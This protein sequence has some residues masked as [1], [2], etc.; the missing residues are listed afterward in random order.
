MRHL[1]PG[2]SDTH[3]LQPGI[4]IPRSAAVRGVTGDILEDTSLLAYRTGF[5]R[6]RGLKGISALAAFP[7]WL[8][9][10]IAC[11]FLY[12]HIS[13]RGESVVEWQPE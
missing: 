6:Y 5:W 9:L 7:E 1:L 12:R 4:E 13:S 10:F 3:L 11:L 8:A 2:P